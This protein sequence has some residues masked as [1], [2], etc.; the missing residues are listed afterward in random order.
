MAIFCPASGIYP[1]MDVI[2]PSAIRLQADCK[3]FA[4][5]L[6]ERCNGFA[7]SLASRK[8]RINDLIQLDG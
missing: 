7:D 5:V 2:N 4:K 1:K 3:R 6:Q 8:D